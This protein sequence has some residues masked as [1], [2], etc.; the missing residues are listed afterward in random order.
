MKTFDKIAILC[1]GLLVLG[2]ASKEQP[3][4]ESQ[5]DPEKK[6]QEAREPETRT[7]TFVLP[8][9][10]EKTAWVEGDAIVVHGEYAKEQVTVTLKA[11]EISDDKKSA[12]VTVEGLYPYVNEECTSTLYAAWPAE[13]VEN[14]PH[15]FFYTKFKATDRQLMAAYNDANDKFQFQNICGSL[16]FET[17]GDYDSFTLVGNMKETLGY[18][19]MQVLLT[20]AEQNFMQYYG[21][22]VIQMDLKASPVTTIYFPSNIEIPSGFFV[23]FRNKEGQFVKSYRTDDP[24][25]IERNKTIE[26]GDISADLVTYVDPFSA[27]VKDIDEDGNAN[28]Y[29]ITEP[30]KYKFKAVRGNDYTSYVQG[31]ASA[32]VLWET[33]NDLSAVTPGSVLAGAAYAEDYVIVHTPDVLHPGN[34]VVAVR[35][36][37]GEILWSWHI[38]IPKTSI[39]TEEFGGIMGA[40]VMDRNLGALVAAEAVAQPLD[41]LAYGMVYQWGRKD[42]F[43]GPGGLYTYFND[44]NE[45]KQKIIQA[46]CAGAEEEADDGD[47]QRTLSIDESIAN[48]RLLTHINDGDW[49]KPS[50]TYLWEGEEDPNAKTIY[51]PCPPGYKVPR[52]TSDPFWSEFASAVGWE[53]NVDC[54]WITMGSP[55]SVFP[56]GGYRD[57]YEVDGFTHVGDRVL[58]WTSTPDSAAKAKGSDLRTDKGTFQINSP[59]KSRLGYIR[60]VA[61]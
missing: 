42:P 46:T 55:V 7:L 56:I 24:I 60:C 8:A 13:A 21:G 30:G 45:K 22:P 52:K 19:Y 41:T 54:G 57:D 49:L 10:G 31:A 34:A 18:D 12:T 23:K 47:T 48:P 59:A 27:D 38:W 43:T 53:V 11:G 44:K 36:S 5:T 6:E 9:D 26:L 25:K 35:D 15:C 16:S 29:I 3:T 28:S 2:C 17:G 50:E 37:D 39:K 61:E 40:P 14:L 51:D 32:D 20:D 1:M 33:W 58:F 4:P